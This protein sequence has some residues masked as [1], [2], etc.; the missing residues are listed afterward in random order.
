MQMI[1]CPLYS[2]SSGN[3]TLVGYGDTRVLVDCGKSGLAIEEA[4]KFIGEDPRNLN[5][6]VV[7]HE[8]HDH[9]AGIGVMARRYHIPIYASHET[10]AAMP[11]GIGKIT[12]GLQR[13]F[14]VGEDFYIGQMGID[15]F[16]VSHDAAD[17]CGFRL[18][19]GTSSVSV[20]T[21][22][23]YAPFRVKEAI[24]GSDLILLESNYDPEMLHA[25]EHYRYALKKRIESRSGHLSNSEC[26]DVLSELVQSGTSHFIL[27][28]LSGENNTPE[29]AMQTTATRLELEG[30]RLDEDVH[31][32][33]A[34]RD[35]VGDI[36]S[37][38]R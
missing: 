12:E 31:V 27:G 32:S 20:V 22:I 9:V 34:W 3:A 18:W 11:Q 21:D 24:E 15:S 38:G 7:T 25:N 5:A 23:G 35:R 33:M 28:H 36:F 8:H 29:L 13:E 16:S 10:W 26:A 6:I 14:T 2:G 37:V 4:L 19:G 17:P 30:L 1:F